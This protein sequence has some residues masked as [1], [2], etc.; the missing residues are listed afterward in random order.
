MGDLKG[1]ND[2]TEAELNN[3]LPDGFYHLKVREAGPG[4][5]PDGRIR[6]DAQT[7]VVSGE[8]A[9][10]FGPRHSWNFDA[11]D[12]PDYSYS[13]EE[14]FTTFI[15]DVKSI[16]NGGEVIVS[17]DG[18]DATILQE[19]G[20]QIKDDEFIA[21]VGEKNGWNVIVG[22]PSAMANPPKGFNG[23]EV[24]TGFSIDEV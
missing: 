15:K 4:E 3:L 17:G 8:Q 18:V 1:F 22:H 5:W 2:Y 6:F 20:R 16:R 12:G 19:I 24:A 11:Y 10:K 9:G 13:E 21:K 7:T 23:S 14:R